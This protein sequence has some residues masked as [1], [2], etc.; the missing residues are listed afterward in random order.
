MDIRL[1]KGEDI[2]KTK[3]NSC[4]HYATNGNIFG[5]EWYLRNTAKEWDALVEN[6]YESVMPLIHR[7]DK[8]GRQSLYLPPLVRSAGIY[9]VNVLSPFRIKAFLDAIPASYEDRLIALNTGTHQPSD[10]DFTPNQITNSILELGSNYEKIS[11]QYSEAF[12]GLLKRAS[13]HRLVTSSSVKPEKLADFYRLQTKQYQGLDQRYHAGLR[14]MYNALHRGWGF[15]TGVEDGKGNL[16]ATS[17]FIHSHGRL[18]SLFPSQ[19]PEGAE[20]GALALLCDLLIRGN[21]SRSVLI[22]FNTPGSDW[23]EEI[24]EGMDAHLINYTVLEKKRI[25]K[26]YEVF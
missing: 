6:D 18:M 15:A 1:V 8:R 10:I 13:D 11:G 16:L 14:I 7:Q 12:N 17:F 3:W 20:K 22:D 4:V 19:S 5:Y 23:P 26:W 9:S 2:D 21:A 24:L 25:R